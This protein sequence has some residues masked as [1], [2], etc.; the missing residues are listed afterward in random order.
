[1]ANAALS[2]FDLDSVAFIPASQPPHKDT[3]SISSF[4]HRVAMLNLV[5]A[6]TDMFQCNAIEGGLA[7]PSYTIDTLVEL[8]EF[9]GPGSELFFLIGVDAF[10]DI[11]TWKAY[12]DILK[13]INLIVFRRQGLNKLDLVSFFSTLGYSGQGNHWHGNKEQK[14][15]YIT[16]Y[17][18]DNVSSSA[19]R[20]KIQTGQQCTE[21]LNGNV[22]DYIIRNGL[23][24]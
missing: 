3:A 1:M 23:Y 7:T 14:D 24:R 9:Y 2:E 5:C 19:I 13:L 22:F 18:P 4:D 17:T 16:Q 6:D 8:L 21:F 15:I 20:K 11:L 12:Q 10:I